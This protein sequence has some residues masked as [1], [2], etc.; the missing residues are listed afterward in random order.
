MYGCNAIA[1]VLTYHEPSSCCVLNRYRTARRYAGS[2][3]ASP[4]GLRGGLASAAGYPGQSH[5]HHRE[6]V[7]VARMDCDQPP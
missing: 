1:R 4:R 5:G 3:A 2:D 7:V 6:A